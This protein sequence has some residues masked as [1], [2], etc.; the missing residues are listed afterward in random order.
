LEFEFTLQ[1]VIST[2]WVIFNDSGDS[3]NDRKGGMTGS[4]SLVN[5][6]H[7]RS[8]STKRHK[9]DED[10]EENCDAVTSKVGSIFSMVP[11]L[12]LNP[13]GSHPEA[14]SVTEVDDEEEEAKRKTTSDATALSSFSNARK[15]ACV[16]LHLELLLAEGDNDADGR[17]GLFGIACTLA[18]GSHGDASSR[19]HDVTE[20]SHADH[21]EW[22]NGEQDEG[23]T[24]AFVERDKE[25]GDAHE[26]GIED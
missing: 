17:Q 9:S 6:S 26:D 25:A 4:L 11:V 19:F 14:K 16:V 21:H 18:V 10:T 3:V 7:G 5:R 22:A 15:E 12:L 1:F 24:P 13:D 20:S 8:S 2:I 23:E